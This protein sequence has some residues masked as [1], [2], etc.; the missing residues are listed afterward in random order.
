MRVFLFVVACAFS[1]VALAV[2]WTEDDAAVGACFMAMDRDP[3]LQ[4]VNAKFARR[5][6]S[7]AQFADASVATMEEQDELRLRTRKTKRCRELR[8]AAVRMHRALL[9][10]SYRILYYQSDQ[11]FDYLGQQFV[12]YGMANRLENDALGAFRRR[13]AS[14]LAANDN[15]ARK[16]L[17]AAWEE[18]LQRAHSN[19]P[20]DG[21]PRV[22]RWAE[23]N[24]AC[25]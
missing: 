21:G 8:L 18:A 7:A 11:I 4:N 19:P 5:E 6:P 13:E 23:L 22:C 17:A 16:A 1:S 12:S 3:A 25:D 2:S 15:G 9:E 10:P 20:P 24:I 14:Y